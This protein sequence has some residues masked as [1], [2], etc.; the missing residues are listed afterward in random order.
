VR[1]AEEQPQPSVPNR[2]VVDLSWVAD[3]PRHTVSIYADMFTD[4]Q[5][6]RKIGKSVSPPRGVGFVVSGT[7]AP[8]QCTS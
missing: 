8:S 7:R 1:M 6:S 5:N 4:I 3:E 2:R